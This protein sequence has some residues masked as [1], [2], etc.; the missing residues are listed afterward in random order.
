[1]T[2]RTIMFS[3]VGAAVVLPEAVSDVAVPTI[4]MTCI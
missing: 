2:V 1:M 3:G 4:S